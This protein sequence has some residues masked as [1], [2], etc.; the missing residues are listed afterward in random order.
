MACRLQRATAMKRTYRYVVGGAA[1][2][3][4]TALHFARSSKQT[5]T[6]PADAPV[7]RATSGADERVASP[8]SPRTPLVMPEPPS[9]AGHAVIE[10]IE[11]SRTEVC[12]GEEVVVTVTA[13]SR[14]DGESYLG[15]EVLNR[16]ELVGP[17]FSLNP[18]QSLARGELKVIA[19]GKHG[20]V[21]VGDVPAVRV[22]D[23]DAP[24]TLALELRRS[25]DAMDRAWLTA[26]VVERAKSDGEAGFEAASYEWD[27]G[28]GKKTTTS[29]PSVRHSYESRSHETAYSYFPVR[30]TAKDA[31]G[32]SVTG[33]RTLR[34]VNLG[35]AGLKFKDEVAIFSGFE[36][37]PSGREEIWLYHG[38]PEEVELTAVTVKDVSTD[39]EG[40][41]H[42]TS[43]SYEPLALLGVARL[44]P[45]ESVV[46]SDLTELEPEAT[47][48][49]RSVEVRGRTRRGHD[50]NG[51]F[52]LVAASPEPSS[53]EREL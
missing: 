43:R 18:V 32:A 6:A 45:G 10:R 52:T 53:D 4:L 44:P 16:P 30:V 42:T 8:L 28:D 22:A 37:K 21:A 23:C 49:V 41:E 48:S 20:D 27:F 25:A 14:D 24:A 26:H 47:R 12:R 5:A 50:A 35:F 3:G 39:A 38:G 11:V 19:R 15:F 40:R 33:S 2:A 13:R 1:L 36:R 9:P 7:K 51:A 17:R 31:R 46:L 34:F 29:E